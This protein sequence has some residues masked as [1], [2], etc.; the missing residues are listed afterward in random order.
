M[1]GKSVMEYNI[2]RGFV[3]IDRKIMRFFNCI[4][5]IFVNIIIKECISKKRKTKDLIKRL[6]DARKGVI[7]M[8]KIAYVTKFWFKRSG[9]EFIKVL[10]LCKY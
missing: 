9:V 6:Y 3:F 8:L 5:L 2:I 10:K 1:K 4:I 7:C